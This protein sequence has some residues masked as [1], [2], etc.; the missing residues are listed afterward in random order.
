MDDDE[1]KKLP[2][3][4]QCV[5]K[6]W[7]ARVNG[8][9]EAAKLFRQI[10]DDKSPEF[11]K[12]LGLI[13]KFVT[14][15]NAAGQEKGL[16][17]ALAYLENYHHAGKTVGDVM[18]GIVT[19]CIAA[20]KTKTRELALQV[21][22]MYIEI[23]KTDAVEEELLKGMEQKNPKIVAACINACTVALKEF[24]SKVINLKPL[25][26]K[27]G[28]LFGDRDKAVRDEARQMVIEMFKWIGA[29]LRSVLFVSCWKFRCRM[30]LFVGL[31]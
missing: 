5:H 1:Y 8:Y 12:Y 27:I 17:A 16:E 29:P 31:G 22:L 9:E 23:E 14:D 25:V 10:D 13:K 7:K 30:F 3:E 19:K 28:T 2:I 15:S 24:G 26:K 11:A 18:S 4:D 21:T 20:Q 6:L